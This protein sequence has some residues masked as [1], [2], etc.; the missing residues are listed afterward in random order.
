MLKIILQQKQTVN[1]YHKYWKRIE[2]FLELTK[3]KKKKKQKTRKSNPS[4][5]HVIRCFFFVVA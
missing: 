3:D 2:N 5:L 4:P 1:R